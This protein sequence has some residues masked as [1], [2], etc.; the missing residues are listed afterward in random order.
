LGMSEKGNPQPNKI[1]THKKELL[2]AL[3]KSRGIVSTACDSVG[4]SRT[5]FYDYVNNDPEFATAVEEVNE[6]AI[7]FVESKLQE[8]ISGIKVMSQQG[9][10][11]VPPSDTAIIFFLKTKAKKRGYVERTES[12]IITEQPLFGDDDGRSD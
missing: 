2:E 3:A 9:V 6:A 7:D 1:D 12:Q 8:K 10:Y 11:E 4:L 5:T